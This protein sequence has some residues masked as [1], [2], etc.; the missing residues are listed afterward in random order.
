MNIYRLEPDVHQTQTGCTYMVIIASFQDISTASQVVILP[1]YHP[2]A[3][4]SAPIFTA[5]LF[6]ES[7]FLFHTGCVCGVFEPVS[8]IASRAGDSVPSNLKS[9][10][11]LGFQGDFRGLN[12]Q[13]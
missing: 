13:E 5:V 11:L 12:L 3:M 10:L 2:R 7:F 4:G 8:T 6:A 9:Q 1:S